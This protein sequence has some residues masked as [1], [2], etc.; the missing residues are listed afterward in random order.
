MSLV[1]FPK[2]IYAGQSLSLTM[3]ATD[4]DN[5]FPIDLTNV[6]AITVGVPKTGGGCVNESMLSGGVVINGDP[7]LGNFTV[8]FSSADTADF[9]QSSV[10]SQGNVD[11]TTLQ[12][13]TIKITD[14]VNLNRQPYVIVI[15]QA[16]AVVESP[17]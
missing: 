13:I 14:S 9:L 7:K 6:T 4:P 1:V 10:D 16:L 2:T 8:T 3:Y 17:C 11:P 15:S 12:P 5:N